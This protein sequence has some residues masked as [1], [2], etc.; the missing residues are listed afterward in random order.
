MAA[1]NFTIPVLD[2]PRL[3]LRGH[4]IDDFEAMVAIWQDP[5]VMHHFHVTGLSRE[6]IWGRFVRSFGMWAVSGY[7][8]WAV[9]DKATGEYAGIAGIFDG[10][11]ELVPAVPA[12]M[13]EA[14]WVFARKFHGKGYATETMQAALHWADKALGRPAMFAIVA[15]ANTASIRVA[16]K[17]GFKPWYD[18]IYH[19]HPTAVLQRAPKKG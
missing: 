2:T 16:E 1:I 7:G 18:T 19:D 3:I 6:E 9:E 11:R 10:K 8:F 12:Y 17:C 14:G 13:P 15:P 5:E 4:R